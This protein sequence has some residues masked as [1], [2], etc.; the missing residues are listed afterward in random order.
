MSHQSYRNILVDSGLGV[1]E[2]KTIKVERMLIHPAIE[3]YI[4]S[5]GE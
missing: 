1:R 5:I 3:E 4:A 2:R